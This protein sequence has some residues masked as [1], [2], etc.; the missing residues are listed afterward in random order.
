MKELV[1]T[2][3][4]ITEIYGMTLLGHFY[5]VSKNV[6]LLVLLIIGACICVLSSIIFIIILK[7]HKERRIDHSKECPYF[8]DKYD[9]M[10]NPEYIDR[11][12]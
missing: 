1:I 2:L 5:G 6:V 10:A 7:P 3:I 4:C 8:I 11:D 9:D 12:L